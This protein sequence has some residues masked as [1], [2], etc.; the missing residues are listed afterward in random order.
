MALSAGRDAASGDKG[1]AALGWTAVA[2][3]ATA[4]FAWAACCVLPMALATV[5]LGL[6]ATAWIAGQRTWLTLIAL[7]VVVVGGWLTWR[8]SRRCAVDTSC[9]APSRLTVGL[10]WA[11][12]ALLV[13]ALVWQPFVE[14]WALGL[15][16]SVRA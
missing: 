16:R 7:A 6:G 8:R 3:S 9:R 14:P 12:G 4:V 15:L 11:A 1:E 2:A 5:G 13:L 10:L